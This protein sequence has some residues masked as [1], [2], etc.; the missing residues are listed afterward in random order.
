MKTSVGYIGADSFSR[1]RKEQGPGG[2]NLAG[3][4]EMAAEVA[5]LAHLFKPFK[6]LQFLSPHGETLNSG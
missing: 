3:R 5:E 2:K 1:Q 4:A 6:G